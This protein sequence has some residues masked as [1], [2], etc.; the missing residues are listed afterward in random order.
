M[1]NHQLGKLTFIKNFMKRIPTSLLGFEKIFLKSKS[2]NSI[3]ID[4]KNMD[5]YCIGT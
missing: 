4:R 3:E 5:N 2:E 1:H